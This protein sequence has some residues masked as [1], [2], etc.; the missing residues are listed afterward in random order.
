MELNLPLKKGERPLFKALELVENIYRDYKRNG[1]EYET[2]KSEDI[3]NWVAKIHVIAEMLR[4]REFMGIRQNSNDVFN[5]LL[6]LP[7]FFTTEQVKNWEVEK[8]WNNISFILDRAALQEYEISFET[9]TPSSLYQAKTPLNEKIWKQWMIKT[10]IKEVIE[11]LEYSAQS[12]LDWD[13]KRSDNTVLEKN[14]K[15]LSKYL[16]L[17]KRDSESWTV[18]Q[19]LANKKTEIWDFYL[20]NNKDS[21]SINSL[22][23]IWEKALNLKN[24]SIS[25]LFYEDSDLVSLGFLK[26]INKDFNSWVEC[27]KEVEGLKVP[28]IHKKVLN[29]DNILNLFLKEVRNDDCPIEV[30]DYL[31]GIKEKINI[32][33]KLKKGK[34]LI[35]GKPLSGKR[36]LVSGILK[37]LNYKGFTIN[38]V[39]S[40]TNAQFED[41]KLADKLLSAFENSA[42]IIN[43]AEDNYSLKE[44]NNKIES[45]SLQFWTVSEKEKV[46]PNML[47]DFDLIIELESPPLKQ[48]I[49]IAKLFF[50]DDSIAIRVA[51]SIKE[52]FEI[53]RLGKLCSVAGDYSWSQ[54]L[55]LI[56]SFSVLDS[57]ESKI[58]LNKL[59]NDDE[60]TPLVG[61]PDLQELLKHI[62]EFYNNPNKYIEMGAK[63]DKGI[64]LVGPPGTGKTHFVRNLSKIVDI[65]I[66]APE[67]SIIAKNIDHINQMFKDLKKNAPCILFL[68]EI[69]TLI[70]SPITNFSIDLE[71][72]KIVNS[73]LSNIDGIESNDGILIVGA[74]HRKNNF[75]P[76]ATRSGRLSKM[77]EL[78]LPNKENRKEIWQA[79]LKNKKIN[80]EINLEELSFLSA[81]FSCADIMESANK[82]AK[83]AI[84]SN[85]NCISIEDLRIACDETY[86]GEANSN[87][88]VNDNQNLI[89][90]YHEAGHAILAWKNGY[91]V[92][93]ITIR[94]RK[95]FLGATHFLGDEGS[96]NMSLAAIR[97]G[98]QV[99]LGG[100][101]AEKIMLGHYEDG[102]IGDLEQASNLLYR[103][104]TNAGLG[105]EGPLFLQKEEKWSNERKV[106]IE[107]EEKKLMEEEF[108]NTENYLNL[109]KELLIEVSDYLIRHR[110]ASGRIMTEFKNKLLS[111]NNI[112]NL[113]FNKEQ[114][115]FHKT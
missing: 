72:Q 63:A 108:A 82:A 75:D 12:L 27:W 71:K 105:D 1:N 98:I 68:D 90:A 101:C 66:F 52:V 59:E 13:K 109:N 94:P 50:K 93:R 65:P 102:G 31:K 49:N 14:I 46:H 91:E 103:A 83:I 9:L 51:Q 48:R 58:P 84:A 22:M 19:I 73:F 26:P 74:T 76:A 30:F 20:K 106:R 114:R 87:T 99:S 37:L 67:T 88:I 39:N 29:N 54:I 57:I 97:E 113:S 55:L 42:L 36:T 11:T 107:N 115:V 5:Y 78:S 15:S 45:N 33:S 43:N 35:Y 23:Y 110:E 34:I 6:E 4:L 47:K 21:D 62:V 18:L 79:H 89:T 60:I 85:N 24:E 56:N 2:I 64:V 17:N 77:I 40:E 100:I 95:D 7:I 32:I 41:L 70:A 81:G 44:K 104:I 92:Q 8:K 3:I 38:H 96:H 86:W 61:Y 111:I 28:N 25:S 16:S 112:P 53:V 80:S 10:P 69:D